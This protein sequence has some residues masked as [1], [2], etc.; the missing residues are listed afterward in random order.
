MYAGRE[1][2]FSTLRDDENT[3]RDRLLWLD[4]IESNHA[5]SSLTNKWIETVKG[6]HCYGWTKHIV[7]Q[8]FITYPAADGVL[9]K[10]GNFGLFAHAKKNLIRIKERKSKK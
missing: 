9:V 8:I 4:G 3:H 5:P 10:G 1:E 2:I 6:S 7:K